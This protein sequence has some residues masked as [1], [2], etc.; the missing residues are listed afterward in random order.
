MVLEKSFTPPG[1]TALPVIMICGGVHRFVL[2]CA[3]GGD[4]VALALAP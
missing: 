2:P 4:T 1:L 3:S